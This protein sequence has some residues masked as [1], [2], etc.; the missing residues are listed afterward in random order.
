M[1]LI[2]GITSVLLGFISIAITGI[3]TNSTD[4][5]F[6]NF[7]FGVLS[8]PSFVRESGYGIVYNSIIF[9]IFNIIYLIGFLLNFGYFKKLDMP[10][11]RRNLDLISVLLMSIGL[12]GSVIS[13]CLTLIVYDLPPIVFSL[14]FDFIF[15][16]GFYTGIIA[17]ITILIEYIIFEKTNIVETKDFH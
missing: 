13:T 10:K 2:F 7:T 12:S 5:F 1:I 6:Y 14:S 4:T 17:I 16:P 11:I 15:L 9:L 3:S 8:I